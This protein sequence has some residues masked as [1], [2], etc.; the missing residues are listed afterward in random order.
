MQELGLIVSHELRERYEAQ[1]ASQMPVVL[2]QIQDYFSIA[3]RVYQVVSA[4]QLAS[5]KALFRP[6]DGRIDA[7]VTNR[8]LKL[9][10]RA[11]IFDCLFLGRCDCGA[12][13]DD[14]KRNEVIKARWE[15]GLL[16]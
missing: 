9:Q 7:S 6:A 3:N 4:E 14:Q 2:K 12:D 16:L 10:S 11:I 8:I 13:S 1:I 5:S 15:G